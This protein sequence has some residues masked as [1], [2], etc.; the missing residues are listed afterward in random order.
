MQ[1]RVN[2]WMQIK[3]AVTHPLVIAMPS[4]LEF[5]PL[6]RP[7]KPSRFMISITASYVDYRS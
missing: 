6:Y 5:S 1:R 4:R 2:T 7:K 3:N